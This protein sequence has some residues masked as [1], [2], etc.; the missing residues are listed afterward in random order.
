M[1]SRH[2]IR[3]KTSD[4]GSR[5][6]S[7]S[8]SSHIAHLSSPTLH[9][10]SLLSFYFPAIYDR[11]CCYPFP[12]S[13]RDDTVG[14]R[15]VTPEVNSRRGQEGASGIQHLSSA[16]KQMQRPSRFLRVSEEAWRLRRDCVTH[17]FS[18]CY[19]FFFFFCCV[20]KSWATHQD[21]SRRRWILR[22]SEFER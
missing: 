14:R 21:T 12:N 22:R 11:A 16:T 4:K 15:G 9:F 10:A 17:D 3:R 19:Y 6:F 8:S 20:R 13:H 2:E 7:A 5:L 1:D 18:F